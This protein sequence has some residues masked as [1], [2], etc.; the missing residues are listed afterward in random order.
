M[1]RRIIRRRSGER[2]GISLP[3]AQTPKIK[4]FSTIPKNRIPNTPFFMGTLYLVHCTNKKSAEKILR[5]K[6]IKSDTENLAWGGGGFW[7][8]EKPLWEYGDHGV[9]VKVTGKIVNVEKLPK[10]QKEWLYERIEWGDTDSIKRWLDR[11][12][13]NVVYQPDDWIYV[14]QS[15]DYE[16]IG[17]IKRKPRK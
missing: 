15:A 7:A 1:R 9:V 6:Y 10:H 13:V 4:Q 3:G 11:H 8:G 12:G 14:R 17:V 2:R 5:Q 16:P